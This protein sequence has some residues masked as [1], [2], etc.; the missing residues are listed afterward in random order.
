MAINKEWAQVTEADILEAN[1]NKYNDDNI[2]NYYRNFEDTKYTYIEYEVI[3]K[4]AMEVLS[5]GLGRSV[6][7]VDMCG[8]AGKAAF[9]MIQCNSACE[10]SLVDLSV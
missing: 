5:K 4:T 9:I 7:A 8:G 3:L 2:I 1:I 10:I 6:K